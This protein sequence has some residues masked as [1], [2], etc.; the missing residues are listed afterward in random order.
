M[1]GDSVTSFSPQRLHRPPD[2][3]QNFLIAELGARFVVCRLS[4]VHL[5]KKW[6]LTAFRL[7]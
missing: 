7:Y 4:L 5:F 3:L 6:F 2:H 1:Y